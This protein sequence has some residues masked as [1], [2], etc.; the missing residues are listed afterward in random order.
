MEKGEQ[1]VIYKVRVAQGL[2][3]R[4][5]AVSVLLS[6]SSRWSA[7]TILTEELRRRRRWG[8]WPRYASWPRRPRQGWVLVPR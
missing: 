5:V 1:R 7:K 4:G 2:H 3:A 8:R 6:V